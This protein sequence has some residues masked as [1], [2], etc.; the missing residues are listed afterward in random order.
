LARKKDD[1]ELPHPRLNLTGK[2]MMVKS[3][4]IKSEETD[5]GFRAV[6]GNTTFA[7]GVNLLKAEQTRLQREEE[8]TRTAANKN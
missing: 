2:V 1:W 7:D 4:V 6:S 8:S 5:G 3:L